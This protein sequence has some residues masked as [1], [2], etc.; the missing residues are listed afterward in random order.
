[1]TGETAF[2]EFPAR[3]PARPL[4]LMTLADLALLLVGFFVLLQANQTL[5]PH[6]LAECPLNTIDAATNKQGLKHSCRSII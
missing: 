5:D 3:A 2:D 1:M 6:K 4:W